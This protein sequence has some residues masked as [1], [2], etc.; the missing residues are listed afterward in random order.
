MRSSST[1]FLFPLTPYIVL[2]LL[3]DRL[4]TI[5]PFSSPGQVYTTLIQKRK[6]NCFHCRIPFLDLQSTT[7]S[8]PPFIISNFVLS[9]R[10]KVGVGRLRINFLLSQTILLILRRESKLL[11]I[12]TNSHREVGKV[13]SEFEEHH[14]AVTE[15][16]S[17]LIMFNL[18]FM[19]TKESNKS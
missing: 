9:E 3:K 5:S 6:K 8:C 11:Y 15:E 14:L 18:G 19:R 17:V 7:P 1:I 16:P 4:I 13:M 2:S 12:Y 10:K